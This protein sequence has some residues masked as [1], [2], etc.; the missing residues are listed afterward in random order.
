MPY[1]TALGRDDR[2]V[3]IQA[4]HYTASFLPHV[5]T[6]FHRPRVTIR[7]FGTEAYALLLVAFLASNHS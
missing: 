4:D 2:L 7:A 5:K 1:L 6:E 3:L